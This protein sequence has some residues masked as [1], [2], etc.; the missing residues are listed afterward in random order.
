MFRLV[1]LSLVLLLSACT[2]S[3]VAD[4]IEISPATTV[5]LLPL[6]NHAQTPLAG[7]RAEDILASI[8]QQ[9]KLPKLL[10]AP[11]NS[12]KDLPPLDD[13]YRLNNAMQWLNTQQ[14]DYVLSGSIEE[15]RYKAGLDGE[16]VV[17]LTLLLT[18]YGETTPIWTGTIAKSGWGRDSIAATAQDVI[19]DLVSYIEV[20]E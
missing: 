12:S 6:V 10:R 20:S 14:A 4:D 1:I 17:A 9:N 7:E 2:T 13:Q 8:W 5:A 15:W 18:K 3:R 19:A 16:P 11:R